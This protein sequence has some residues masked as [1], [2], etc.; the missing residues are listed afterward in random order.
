M[1]PDDVREI[2]LDVR[3]LP[4]PEPMVLTLERLETLG[5]D[6]VLVHINSRVPVYLLPILEERGWRYEVSHLPEKSV[7]VR[8]WGGNRQ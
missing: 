7:Q 2:M 3:G 4:P 1:P 6:E 5:P 8:I